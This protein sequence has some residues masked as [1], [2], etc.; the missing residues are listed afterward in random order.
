MV[1]FSVAWQDFPTLAKNGYLYD[2]SFYAFQIARNIAAGSG[3]TFD[4]STLTNGF[5]PLYVALITPMYW[6]SGGD[7]VLPV[8][9][10]LAL[11]A[12]LTVAT[13]YVMFRILRRY[14]D[15]AIALSVAALWVISPVVIRQAANGLETAL[16]LFMLSLSVYYYLARVRALRPAPR[17]NL[18]RLGVLLGLTVLA[19]LDQVFLVLAIAL[20]Y[21]LLARRRR[22]RQV[23]A[24]GNVGAMLG[25]A[26]AV[27]S[28]WLVY[29]WFALGR[30]LPES[31]SATRF[32]SLAYAPF[33]GLGSPELVANGPDASFLWAHVTRAVSVLKLTPATHGLFRAIERVSEQ[34]AVGQ[35]GAV[36]GNVFGLLLLVGFV[37]W[38]LVRSRG[39]DGGGMRELSFLIL[40]SVCLIAAYSLYVFG[41]FFFIRYFYPVYFV[42]MIFIAFAVRDV[43]RWLGSARVFWR[44]ALVSA[45]ALYAIGHLYMVYN[46]CYRSQPVYHFYDVAEW[47]EQ[48]TD[49]H[50][51]IGVFQSG[52]IGYLSNRRVI[53]LDGKVNHDAM[54]ALEE[55]RLHE[56]IQDAGIDVLMD[57]TTVIRLFLGQR[58]RF[59]STRFYSGAE[60]GLPGWI[61]YR[62]RNGTGRGAVFAG[63][64]P[65]GASPAR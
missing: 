50:D 36:A 8:H 17:G 52:T 54:A 40:F 4:G 20:D 31:G 58:D 6:L 1:H 35:W 44:R 64:N 5:Q 22:G 11:L 29:G 53:N 42:A 43:V 19:R 33:F 51:T 39:A 49:E 23:G 13:A 34:T 14:V 47:V 62:L 9:L 37:A 3:P 45:C 12:L 32:L 24:V 28:P 25:T 15:D 48:N 59:A 16:A 7:P 38:V 41:V 30:L 57:H 60:C 65:G 27:Y 46:C 18:V 2:D 61:G 56:Y 21:L 55:G 63:P 10:A 26:F